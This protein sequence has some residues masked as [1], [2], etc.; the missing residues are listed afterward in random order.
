M[1]YSL[2]P[3]PSQPEAFDDT[4]REPPPDIR[5]A[6]ASR[7]RPKNDKAIANAELMDVVVDALHDVTMPF[8]ITHCHEAGGDLHISAAAAGR[9]YSVS[10][11]DELRGGLCIRNSESCRFD[12]LICTRLFCVVCINGMLMECDKEQ[13]FTVPKSDLP[14][15]NWR[16]QIL[17]VVQRS[18][19]DVALKLD[20][21]RFEATARQML[22]TPYEFL[23]HMTAQQ[24]I[25]DEEQSQIQSIFNENA[26]YTLYGLIN[27]VT[28]SAH[29]HRASARWPRAFEIERP[30]GEILQG[31]HNL[32]ALD[33]AFS[34]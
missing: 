19:D 12:T 9:G 4:P 10:V 25:T 31:D 34:R 22:V 16:T 28:Q 6:L 26:D 20:F 29:E 24:L 27:A 30:A 23:C 7:P 14:P 2:R 13:S 5:A 3:F 33:A 17:Q 15:M 1:N 8:H 21:Q 32:P 11:G 18:F